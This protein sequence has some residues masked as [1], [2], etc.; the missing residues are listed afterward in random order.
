M[1]TRARLARALVCLSLV[2]IP[3]GCGDDTAPHGA[4]VVAPADFTLTVVNSGA[5]YTSITDAPLAFQ[6]RDKNG[7][8][9]PGVLMRFY[10][11]GN[12]SQTVAL[13]DRSGVPLN[14]VD[15]VFFETVTDERGLSPKDVYA[16]FDVPA[17]NSTED[18]SVTANVTAS[19]GT[20][21]DEWVLSITAS[22]C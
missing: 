14:P 1:K 3:L 4:T 18:V 20:A 21:S 10:G 15:P 19:V 17:C 13:T 2:V 5:G 12:L 22:Q 11:G 8:P 6:A 7:N 9:L 16:A